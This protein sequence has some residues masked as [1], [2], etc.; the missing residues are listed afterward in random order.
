[1]METFIYDFVVEM[2]NFF[3]LLLHNRSVSFGVYLGH[4]FR[5]ALTGSSQHHCVPH[6]M[7]PQEWPNSFTVTVR[8]LSCL[9]ILS[10]YNQP[11]YSLFT[12]FFISISLGILCCVPAILNLD[13]HVPCVPSVSMILFNFLNQW[14][15][16]H[17]Y[18]YT[19]SDS[20]KLNLIKVSQ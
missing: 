4:L 16:Y 7:S 17:L 1:M 18:P 13:H 10:T 15:E 12:Y 11:K 2:M 8:H 5:A 14:A 9:F 19:P 20:I 3:S 6:P